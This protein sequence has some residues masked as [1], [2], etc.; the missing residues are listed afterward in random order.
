MPLVII[1]ILLILAPVIEIAVFITVGQAIGVWKVVALIVLSAV[2]GIMLLRYKSLSVLKKI[3]R[4]IR[5]GQTPEAGLFDGFLIVAGAILLIIPGFVSD[6]IGLLL[7][8][9][10]VRGG[11]WRFIKSRVTV[12]GFSMGGGAGGFRGRRRQQED[13]VDLPPEDF[14]RREPRKHPPAGEIDHQ[15]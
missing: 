10:F 6:V 3:N 4:E 5:Q 14:Q 1:P 13:V 9:P 15:E 11:V 12:T 8:I 7:L 2:V